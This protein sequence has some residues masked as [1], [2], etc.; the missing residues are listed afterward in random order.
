M[1][2]AEDLANKAGLTVTKTTEFIPAFDS[3]L[4]KYPH[5]YRTLCKESCVDERMLR[6]L[7]N[8]KFLRKESLLAIL[9]AA[10]VNFE[11]IQIV[12]GSAGY[13]LSDSIP[14]EAVIKWMLL[15]NGGVIG[16]N[17]LQQINETLHTYD[18][19]LLMTREY[20]R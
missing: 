17:L 8:G 14:A 20:D 3:V 9:I 15:N 2:E 18:L 6:H 16:F 7:R 10:E 4:K 13:V 5:S 19:P 1:A 12:M 11:D